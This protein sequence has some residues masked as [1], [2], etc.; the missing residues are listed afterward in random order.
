MKPSN[1]TLSL[2]AV[3]S[4]GAAT[5]LIGPASP[6][7]A[8]PEPT[9]TVSEVSCVAED[10]ILSVTLEAGDS[11]HTFVVL[12]DD[13]TSA[14]DPETPVE[15]GATETVD[16]TGLEDGE[17]TVQV[18]LVFTDADAETVTLE[19]RTVACDVA[20]EGPYTNS[21]G[22]VYDLC[23]GSGTVTASNKPIAGA[24][25]NL[26]PVTFEVVFTLVDATGGDDPVDGDPGDGTDPVE[27]P[28]VERATP[29]EGEEVVLDTFVLDAGT[30]TYDRTFGPDELGGS[31]ELTLRSGGETVAT[32]FVGQCIV[33]PVS[34]TGAEESG[35]PAVPATGF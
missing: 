5:A 16:V 33:L 21:K 19:N 14:D 1:R 12:V 32:A 13:M 28:P 15:A 7:T 11:P 23:E 9:A 8:A 35:G 18:L 26:Q 17:H 22:A 20:P 31:G 10:G 29:A 25:E 4:L 3:L 24:V 34:D 6:A 27:E 2:A 30:Q